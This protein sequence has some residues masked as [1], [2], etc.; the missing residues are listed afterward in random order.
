[1]NA[2]K[3]TRL[4][5]LIPLLVTKLAAGTSIPAEYI[6]PTLSEEWFEEGGLSDK[7]LM[8]SNF[9]GQ[10][11]E[12]VTTGA[13]VDGKFWNATLDVSLLA[14]LDT[15]T[16][17]KDLNRLTDATFGLLAT[18]QKVLKSLDQWFP[19]DGGAPAWGLL[20]QP[21]RTLGYTIRPRSFKKTGGWCQ[22]RTRVHMPFRQDLS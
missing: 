6:F 9:A 17:G 4:E 16:P 7:Y 2:G 11:V 5:T 14:R 13:G 10:E 12:S 3:P 22:M 21:A 8:I 18:W 1:M 19:D 15:D 20:L